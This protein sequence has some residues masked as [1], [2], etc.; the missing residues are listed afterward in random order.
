MAKKNQE[1]A[2]PAI[3]T[4]PL[5]DQ[6]SPLVIDLP[7]GQKLVVGNIAHG[8]VIEVA[9]WR[10]T[11]RPDSRTSRLMLGVSGSSNVEDSKS[12]ASEEKSYS[13]SAT[14]KSNPVKNFLATLIA[15]SPKQ[16]RAKAV[17]AIDRAFQDEKEPAENREETRKSSRVSRALDE[18]EDIQSWLDDLMKSSSAEFSLSDESGPASTPKV[19]RVT[20]TSSAQS[21]RKTGGTSRKKSNS[22][23]PTSAKRRNAGKSRSMA[24][25]KR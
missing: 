12:T 14:V 17:E 6:E 4:I 2:P 7:D 9:T 16:K 19:R 10:G 15:K 20:K 23:R 11:G 24:S 1:V 22:T 21:R 18:S 25:K 13:T 5:P 3:S 8:T